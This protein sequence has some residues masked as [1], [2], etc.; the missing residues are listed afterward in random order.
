[1]NFAPRTSALILTLVCLV[2]VSCSKTDPAA[3]N[4]EKKIYNSTG[5]V[6]AVD[7]KNN[8]VTID[9]QDIPGF[10]SAMEMTFS[11]ASAPLLDGMAAGDRVAF[12]LE[13]SG[14]KAAVINISKIS[15]TPPVDGAAVFAGN[16]AKCHGPKGEGTK[17]GIPLISGHALA[18]T[19]EEYV[20]QV[21]NGKP[22][23]MTAFRDKLTD[24]QIAA[25]VKHVRTVIQAGVDPDQRKP[26]QH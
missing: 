5:V 2:A 19:E 18:H 11:V 22:N 16:C 3:S 20:Q 25:V 4:T 6:K 26:H 12:S 14:G 23:K 1:M 17:K 13:R 15:E 10:M 24:K 21:V 9:H 8:K 7:L